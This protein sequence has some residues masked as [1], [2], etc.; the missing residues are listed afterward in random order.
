M[1]HSFIDRLDKQG[2]HN[3]IKVCTLFFALSLISLTTL[4]APSHGEVRETGD[5]IEVWHLTAAGWVSP[6][7]FFVIEIKRLKGTT[8]GTV[9]NYPPYD[10]VEE[11]DTLID[12]LPDGRE[13]PMVF[14]H[15]RWRRLP[16]VLALDVRLRNHGGCKDVFRF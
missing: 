7:E 2:E 9:E 16:D 8:Y 1:C 12:Q 3:M 4:P 6:H 14:F 15:E 10:A 13:C 11:W 5:S